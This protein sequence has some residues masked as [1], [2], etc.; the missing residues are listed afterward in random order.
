MR[1]LTIIAGSVVALLA[2]APTEAQTPA[3]VP[4]TMPFDIPYGTPIG[5]GLAKQVAG[6]A[7]AEMGRHH[8]WKMAVAV[9][10]PSGGLV[11]FEKADGTQ[12][13]SVRI[14]QQKARVAAQFRRPTKVFADAVAS[15]GGVGVLSLGV[16]ASEGGI[17]LVEQGKLVG[18]IGVSG[19]IATQDGAVAKAGAEVVK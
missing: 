8:N 17:P 4:E 18:A 2:V 13:A 14:A 9:V 6:A 12:I 5:I 19:G 1:N 15:S 3:Q 7:V 11:Y 16:V 10:D